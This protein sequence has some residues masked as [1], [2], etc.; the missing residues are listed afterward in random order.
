MTSSAMDSLATRVAGILER[1]S[2]TWSVC[3]RISGETLYAHRDDSVQRSASTI[4]LAIL[5]AALR[6]VSTGRLSLEQE[7]ALPENRA[8]GSGVLAFLNSTRALTLRELLSLMIAVSDNA[9]TNAAID[10]LG[11]PDVDAAAAAAGAE[12]TVLARHMMDFEAV[13]AGRDN[14]TTAR[15]LARVTEALL[16]PGELLSEEF[17]AVAAELLGLQ[18]FE[19]RIPALLPDRFPVLHKTG[20]L[21]G[22]CLD[23]GAVV[24]PDGRLLFLAVLGRDLSPADAHTPGDTIARITRE[25]VDSCASS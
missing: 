18:Q 23:A 6:A 4:K 17:T 19:E 2:G 13:L 3:A 11:F 25:I 9:A 24:L 8:G 1:A 21:D 5:L 7:I 20:E 12:H 14:L 15:D 16:V 10:L 22:I